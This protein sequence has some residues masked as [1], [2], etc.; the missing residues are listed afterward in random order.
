[1]C[2]CRRLRSGHEGGQVP[3]PYTKLTGTDT[4]RVI[5]RI[6]EDAKHI[7]DKKI[8][9]RKGHAGE[10]PHKKAGRVGKILIKRGETILDCVHP[11]IAMIKPTRIWMSKDPGTQKKRMLQ[12]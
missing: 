11:R 6:L 2:M 12:G 3:N 9:N 4:L 5:G 8:R 10:S 1:M 7:F